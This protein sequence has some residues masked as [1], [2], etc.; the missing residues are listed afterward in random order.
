[1]C[2]FNLLIM[3]FVFLDWYFFI[4]KQFISVLVICKRLSIVTIIFYF[5]YIFILSKCT[6]LVFLIKSFFNCSLDKVSS[7]ISLSA[8]TVF[9]SLSISNVGFLQRIVFLLCLMQLKLTQIYLE[10]YQYNLQ[11]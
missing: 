6:S 3:N 8:I 11:Q 10:I 5:I 2:F 9:L 1:M 4:L 7:A